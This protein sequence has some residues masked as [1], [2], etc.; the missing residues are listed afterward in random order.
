M[1]FC[2]VT[3]C[4]NAE[5]HIERTMRSLVTQT[6]FSASNGRSFLEYIVCDGGSTDATLSIARGIAQEF[7]SLADKI[8]IH[9]YSESDSGMYDAIAEGFRR[10]GEA[11][12]YSY[13]NAGDMYSSHAFEVLE[14]VFAITG[15]KFITGFNVVYNE[16]EHMVSCRLPYGY[17]RR[18][19]DTGFYG[20]WLPHVQQESTFWALSLHQNIDFERF[21]QFKLAG[22]AYLW[23]TL[24]QYAELYVVSAWLA[25]FTVHAGQLSQIRAKEYR[26]EHLSICRRANLR[27][28]ILAGWFFVVNYFPDVIKKSFSP[29]LITYDHS[30][31]RYRMS[32]TR[33]LKR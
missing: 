8:T 32:K 29:S 9:I 14:S 2:I 4:F 1:K 12:V 26:E 33:A 19:V 13:I 30:A 21:S 18:L 15:V 3:P 6:A 20:R 27:D 5:Q 22:D 25:G 23:K 11:D 10:A 31:G 28:Y 17:S 7:S 16:H 24:S